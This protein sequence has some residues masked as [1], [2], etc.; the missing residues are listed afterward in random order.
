MPRKPCA[1][2]EKGKEAEGIAVFKALADESRLKI[3]SILLQ[4]DSY[5]AYLADR[6]NLTPP[7]VV[8]HMEK[9]A[10]AGI[11]FSTKIHHYVI[12]SI[13]REMMNRTVGEYIRSV[14][15]YD[16]SKS[17]EEKVIN[18]FFEYGK[19]KQLPAGI[20]KREVIVGA[21]AAQLEMD[22][23]YCERELLDF[24]SEIYEDT[25]TLKRDLVGFGFLKEENGFYIRIK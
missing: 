9:L 2:K 16:D 4:K 22:R 14:V 17:Y 20:K 21:V 3:I 15:Q 7:T 11:V 24:L 18:S 6:L 12:Y 25:P 19:L 8:Y 5:T 10:K 13:N 1:D 23:P